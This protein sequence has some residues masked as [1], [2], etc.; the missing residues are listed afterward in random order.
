MLLRCQ[1]ALAVH[2]GTEFL[3]AGDMNLKFH[4]VSCHDEYVNI[5]FNIDIAFINPET[6]AGTMLLTKYSQWPK[7]R[8]LKE[9]SLEVFFKKDRGLYEKGTM[10]LSQG[11]GVGAYAYLRRILE[12]NINRLINLIKEDSHQFCDDYE[13]LLEK[14]KERDHLSMSEIIEIAKE[15]LPSELKIG[16]INPLQKMYSVL[17][18][19]IHSFDDKECLSRANKINLC[20]IYLVGELKRREKHKKEFIKNISNL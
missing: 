6:S 15:I 13:K 2:Y 18:G 9:K 5:G 14:K 19:G 7:I 20:L 16:G 11:F 3:K 17:S 12:N 4:C 1:G 10:C 8:V